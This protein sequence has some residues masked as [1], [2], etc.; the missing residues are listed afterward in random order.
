MKIAFCTTC[1]GRTPH[2]EQTLPQNLADNADY[3]DAVFVVV[4]YNSRDNLSSYL[5][6]R[7]ALIESGRLVIYR[8]TEPTPFRMAHAKNLAHRLGIREGADVLVNL[9]A[10]NFTGPG[11]ARYVA[12]QFKAGDRL[13]LWSRMVKDGAGKLPRGISG[14]IAV[15][16][17]GFL[18]AGGYDENFSTWSPDD[19]DF[20]ARLT[21]LG[22]EPREIE[23]RHLRAV[24][25]NDRL[26]FKDYPHVRASAGDEEEVPPSVP[27]V[28]NCGR[29]GLGVVY[30]NFG[31]DPIE[32]GP[33]PTRIF[34]IGMHKTGTT[35]LHEAL[36]I[37]GY[38]SAH[39]K[40]ARWAKAIW[41]EFKSGGKSSTAEKSYALSDLPI[42]L[43]YRELDAAY[44]GA[45]FILTIR[46]EVEWLQSVRN[47]W[48]DRNV[49]REQWDGDNFTHQLHNAVYGR[50]TFDAEV[51][52]R[53]YKLHNAM[54]REHFKDRPGDL[55]VM[56][57]SDGAGWWELCGFLRRPI[58]S[59]S[60][61]R[62]HV[63]QQG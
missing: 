30:R 10:D 20:S 45:K 26:R 59:R 3:P 22:Y 46:D 23:P 21:K 29:I 17:R 43:F 15:S 53:R 34:G 8:F 50:K 4:N 37:L 40:S 24:L 25:H 55:L 32:L 13:F 35:S 58:P 27:A 61:P 1:K 54:V 38:D 44:P 47:H 9:D 52:L 19:K 5:D 11:F 39:W 51:F 33:L 42:P 57:M 41:Q 6:G 48:S 56:D 7:R 16:S 63:S 12:D 62:A 49:F 36:S 2:L 18:L 60:Y 28:V 31:P 14:R